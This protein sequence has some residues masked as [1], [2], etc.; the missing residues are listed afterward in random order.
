[1]HTHERGRDDSRFH[2][3]CSKSILQLL[4]EQSG[5]AGHAASATRA[6][7]NDSISS[8]LSRVSLASV[9]GSN[10]RARGDSHSHSAV[11]VQRLEA[12]ELCGA[13]HSC[14][15]SASKRLN[16][17]RAKPRG[18]GTTVHPSIRTCGIMAGGINGR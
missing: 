15:E 1:M 11:Q 2:P 6:R 7:R 12:V 16:I 18:V 14:K 9:V 3:T 5:F 8:A 10:E 13:C 4:A 17:E